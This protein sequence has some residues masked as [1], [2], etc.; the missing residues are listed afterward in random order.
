MTL[1]SAIVV[2]A[3]AMAGCAYQ[4]RTF[5]LQPGEKVIFQSADRANA[6]RILSGNDRGQTNRVV[7]ITRPC[8]LTAE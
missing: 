4:A 7:K 2:V 1:R 6:Y 8:E 3:L 5:P